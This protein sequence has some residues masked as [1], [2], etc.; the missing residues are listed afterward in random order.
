MYLMESSS[1]T[2]QNGGCQGQGG[3]GMGSRLMGTE[4]QMKRILET[5]SYNNVNIINT[6]ELHTQKMVNFMSCV[7]QFLKIH[8][9]LKN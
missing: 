5:G 8:N 6:T 9:S 4:L 3:G 1:K 7:P 2:K